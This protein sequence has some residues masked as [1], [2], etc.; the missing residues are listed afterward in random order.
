MPQF[1]VIRLTFP[2][3]INWSLINITLLQSTAIRNLEHHTNKQILVFPKQSHCEWLFL[4]SLS[5][6]SFFTLQ[7]TLQLRA[8]SDPFPG[9]PFPILWLQTIPQHQ[10][11]M[12]C[13]CFLLCLFSVVLQKAFSCYQEH[14]YFCH[15]Y[16]QAEHEFGL[17]TVYSTWCWLL[18][19]ATVGPK[20]Y[21]LAFFLVRRDAPAL[22]VKCTFV[23]KPCHEA[24]GTGRATQVHIESDLLEVKE[25]KVKAILALTMRHTLL[26]PE[27]APK[28]AC[29][30]KFTQL[31]QARESSSAHATT[32]MLLQADRYFAVSTAY[33]PSPSRELHSLNKFSSKAS[34]WPAEPS[35]FW[36]IVFHPISFSCPQG[37]WKRQGSAKS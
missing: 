13:M 18:V 32:S 12:T 16:L 7:S 14:V 5:F 22:P 15:C 35:A 27:G 8:G 30:G 3:P 20:L 9:S 34:T 17:F 31:A 24:A 1:H 21:R 25:G 4:F 28:A 11:Q 29:Q 36:H 10:K 23:A 37:A 6:L 19:P 33:M 2:S 26:Q